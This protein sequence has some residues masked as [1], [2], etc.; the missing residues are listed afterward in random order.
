MG[1][2]GALWACTWEDLLCTGLW[3]EAHVATQR[4]CA[5]LAELGGCRPGFHAV[6]VPHVLNYW[7]TLCP[8]TFGRKRLDRVGL[9][10]GGGEHRSSV[11][12]QVVRV[13]A[14]HFCTKAVRRPFAA[15]GVVSHFSHWWGV[16]LACLLLLGFLL[17]GRLA[18]AKTR[19]IWIAFWRRCCLI[20]GIPCEKSLGP[21]P[22]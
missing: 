16:H 10:S 2:F 6:S 7:G 1:R 19:N 11:A 13:W 5:S 3:W 12:L 4:T 14:I 22:S 20:G 15:P 9:Q 17:V 21:G 8:Q 18:C